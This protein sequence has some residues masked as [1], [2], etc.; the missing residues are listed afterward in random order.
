[1]TDTPPELAEIFKRPLYP[2]SL[3]GGTRGE[4]WSAE[5]VGPMFIGF[6]LI[7]DAVTA[8][9][10]LLDTPTDAPNPVRAESLN[11]TGAIIKDASDWLGQFVLD[12]A[13]PATD[14]GEVLYEI[15]GNLSFLMESLGEHI[16]RLGH[17]GE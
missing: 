13:D 2:S 6:A 7:N 1:M 15:S 3:F 8:L 14:R 16:G 12:K 11:E 5:E 10:L 9:R 4:V 17:S